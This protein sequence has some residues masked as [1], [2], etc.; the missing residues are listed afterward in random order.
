[1]K[2]SQFSKLKSTRRKWYWNPSS[3]EEGVSIQFHCKPLNLSSLLVPF[4][5]CW[6]FFPVTLSYFSPYESFL[7]MVKSMHDRTKS[8]YSSK[9]LV[10]LVK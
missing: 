6:Y 1:M 3:I 5:N 2:V 7:K 10:F 4:S 8:K 9:N